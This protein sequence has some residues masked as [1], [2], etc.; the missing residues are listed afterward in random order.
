VTG[1]G[2]ALCAHAATTQ[3][4]TGKERIILFTMAILS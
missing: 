4:K 1:T 2:A 3:A